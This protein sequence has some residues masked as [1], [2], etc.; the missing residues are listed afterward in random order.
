MSVCVKI[1]IKIEIE[2]KNQKIVI[3]IFCP[4]RTA[5]IAIV[6]HQS[7]VRVIRNHKDPSAILSPLRYFDVT[8]IILRCFKSDTPIVYQPNIW[9]TR[10]GRAEPIQNYV[11]PEGSV[12]G[13]LKRK[14]IIIQTSQSKLH[15][16]VNQ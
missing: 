2:K 9:Q 13:W 4:Y 6:W 12:G 3:Y 11:S 15:I 1:V 8:V 7:T 10:G 14:P 5:L 16:R